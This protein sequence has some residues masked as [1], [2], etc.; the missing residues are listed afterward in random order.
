MT[1]CQQQAINQGSG[2][3]GLGVDKVDVTKIFR[4]W[5]MV[6]IDE[7]SAMISDPAAGTVQFPGI[8]HESGVKD[9]RIIDFVNKRVVAG[10][11]SIIQRGRIAIVG[12]GLL[13]HLTQGIGQSQGRTE[14]IT[15]RALMGSDQDFLASLDQVND[16][17]NHLAVRLV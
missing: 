6:D 11:K 17:L 7:D 1:T 12:N 14:S 5:V 3:A 15:V 10:E 9:L 13:A 4:V 2:S 16:L 8:Q